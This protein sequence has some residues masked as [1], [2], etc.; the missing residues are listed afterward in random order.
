MSKPKNKS[1]LYAVVR[2][3]DNTPI[4]AFATYEAADNYSGKCDQEFKD[5]KIDR[6]TFTVRSLIYYDE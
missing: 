5:Y 3:P 6:Y 2:L 1:I 4:A